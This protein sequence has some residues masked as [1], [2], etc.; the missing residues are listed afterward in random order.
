MSRWRNYF[1]FLYAANLT[2]FN[3]QW[4]KIS[5]NSD[6]LFFQ[7]NRRIS[8]FWSENNSKF[9]KFNA[10]W[11]KMQSKLGFNIL[12]KIG[13]FNFLIWKSIQIH[14]MQYTVIQNCWE[15]RFFA[16]LQFQFPLLKVVGNSIKIGNKRLRGLRKRSVTFEI[17]QK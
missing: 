8:I 16:F 3:A 10:Q 1:L 13:G 9:T 12:R 5:R 2:K 4:F 14:S 17:V 15:V 11:F 7:K 6:L